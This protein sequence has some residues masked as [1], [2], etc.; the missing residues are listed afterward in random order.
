MDFF[1]TL[2]HAHASYTCRANLPNPGLAHLRIA[3]MSHCS[4]GQ[5][6]WQ[7]VNFLYQKYFQFVSNNK[8][9]YIYSVQFS[10][11]AVYGHSSFF[12]VNVYTSQAQVCACVCACVSVGILVSPVK[13]FCLDRSEPPNVELSY[14]ALA[15]AEAPWLDFISFRELA[16]VSTYSKQRNTLRGLKMW[17]PTFDGD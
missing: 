8:F 4:D 1:P 10:H 5:M 3:D 17:K 6:R 2:R 11:F 12:N 9:P 16:V 14:L 15:E 7:Q 13:G